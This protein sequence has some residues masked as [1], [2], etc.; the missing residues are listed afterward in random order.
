MPRYPL[1]FMKSHLNATYLPCGRLCAKHCPMLCSVEPDL[2][3]AK[4]SKLW[5][6]KHDSVLARRVHVKLTQLS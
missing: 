4:R 2:N 6:D 5:T 1:E 3:P